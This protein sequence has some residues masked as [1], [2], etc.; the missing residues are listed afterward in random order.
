MP[1][2]EKS[3]LTPANIPTVLSLCSAIESTLSQDADLPLS[4]SLSSYVFFPIST[5]FRRN[6]LAQIPDQVLE[7]LLNVLAIL[8]KSW[9]WECELEVWAQIF[10]LCGS[11]LGGSE[12]KG[13]ERIRSDE[14]KQA[15]AE[16]LWALLHERDGSLPDFPDN[17]AHARLASY[18][19]FAQSTR[20]TPV[21]GRTIDSLL[22]T[23]QSHHRP[24]QHT[25]FQLLD[26]IISVYAPSRLIA[27]ILPGAVST[28]TKI[29]LAIHENKGWANG[30]TVTGA[31]HVIQKVVVTSIGDSVCIADGAI[32]S[33]VDLEDLSC[34]NDIA[35]TPG[36]EVETAPYLVARTS[37]WL[38]ASTSQLHIALN[39][40]APLVNHPNPT[41][42]VALAATAREILAATPLTLPQSQPLLLSWLLS[43]STS[44]CPRVADVAQECL[45][46]LLSG[47]PTNVR[48]SLLQTLIQISKDCM[49]SL[50]IS[51]ALQ[52]DAKLEH[53][54]RQLEA[55]CQIA[56]TSGSAEGGLSSIISGIG[57]LLGPSGGIEKWGWTLL[58]VLE[59]QAPPATVP[60]VSATHASLEGSSGPEKMVFPEVQLKSVFSISAGD[61]LGRMFRALGRVTGDLCLYS[62]E[63]FIRTGL[64]SRS[65]TAVP[66]LWCALRLLEGASRICLDDLDSQ[67]KTIANH[68]KKLARF[69]RSLTRDIANLWGL[70]PRDITAAPAISEGDGSLP[71]TEVIKGIKQIRLT[72]DVLEPQGLKAPRSTNSSLLHRALCL[73]LLAISSDIL[74]TN[75]TQLLIYAFYPILQSIVSPVPYCS[76]S[77][78]A[79]LVSITHSTSYA[80]PANLLLSHFDYALDAVFR[81]LHRRWL[82][83]EATKV[84]TILIRLVGNDVVQRAGD[85]VEECFDRL[86]EYH[87]YEV[88]VD[89]L[90]EVLGE[91]VHVM[92]AEEPDVRDEVKEA[93]PLVVKDLSSLLEWVA[94]RNDPQANHDDTEY[95]PAPHTGWHNLKHEAT[96]DGN[97]D[98]SPEGPDSD[99]PLT[100]VQTLTKQM[101]IRSV[102]FLTHRSPIIRARILVLL[103]SATPLLSKSVLLPPIHQAWPFILN[104]LND[105]EIFV[106]S[107]A[108]EL[109]ESLVNHVGSFMGRRIW[110]DVWPR[111]SIVLKKLDAVD[112]RSALARRGHGAVGTDSAYTH[113]HR[114]YRSIIKTLGA[115]VKGV[116][117]HDSAGWEVIL[118]FRRF[119]HKEAHEELQACARE[120]YS[121]LYEGNQGAVWLALMATSGRVAGDMTFL[122]EGRWDLDDNVALILRR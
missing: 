58:S 52:A 89:G 100:P 14:T 31:L 43:L 71:R 111:F 72:V 97:T 7:K 113:S 2:L 38:R 4:V 59:F 103:S 65:G 44:S 122:R 88:I 104:R 77:G 121:A 56:T 106:V 17:S 70:E 49:N 23:V 10:M 61:S 68:G 11:V 107:A 34:L 95:G 109:I 33:V 47:D 48:Q 79:A 114:L 92:E 66:A 105:E 67:G 24:L 41:A 53:I 90:V 32:R 1:L 15:A 120:L 110:D 87:G 78:L 28:M 86:D 20:F 64:A 21:L 16:C 35:N 12:G 116:H 22:T 74:Q 85:V 36:T 40:L 80:S 76:S 108:A 3:Q 9:W 5:I 42:L 50:P 62:V 99:P 19:N 93:N 96:Q 112:S 83:I 26:V 118:S 91:V 30:N 69:T 54:A 51:I 29:A 60:W 102:P 46:G 8:C 55:I 18:R 45:L 98:K 84:L 81:R 63:W 115:A 75:F 119:L 39:A 101:V 13:K 117:M 27:T 57:H 25:S 73:Q 82:D 6:T 94:H 37:S